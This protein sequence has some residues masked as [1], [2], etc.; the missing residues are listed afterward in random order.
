[1]TQHDFIIFEPIVST[2]VLKINDDQINTGIV[3]SYGHGYYENGNYTSQI[4][5]KAGNKILFTNH[6]QIDVYGEKT[7]IT[8]GRDVIKVLD[9]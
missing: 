3:K 8:R 9:E 2:G 1:M 4:S 6:I 7:F 5:I